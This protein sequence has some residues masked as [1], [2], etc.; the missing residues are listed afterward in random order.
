MFK[1]FNRE[2]IYKDIYYFERKGNFAVDNKGF[3]INLSGNGEYWNTEDIKKNIVIFDF[4]LKKEN[5]AFKIIEPAD[6][7]Y[8]DVYKVNNFYVAHDYNLKHDANGVYYII[9][10]LDKFRE[11]KRNSYSF[12]QFN[13]N[14]MEEL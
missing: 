3:L 12:I 8:I 5:L 11:L 9:I 7:D 14:Y 13:D 4:E 10:D 2:K 6:Y 1:V